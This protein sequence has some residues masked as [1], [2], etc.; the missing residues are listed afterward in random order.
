VIFDD[1][2]KITDA[3]LK[4]IRLAACVV[5]MDKVMQPI[6]SDS[7]IHLHFDFYDKFGNYMGAGETSDNI[8]EP[9]EKARF[10]KEKDDFEKDIETM[11]SYLTIRRR[12]IETMIGIADKSE[13]D[14]KIQIMN[15]AEAFRRSFI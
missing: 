4:V 12:I 3:S 2:D 5:Q 8:T 6:R 7:N 11:N 15:L 10:K 1:V 9:S 14:A 13:G